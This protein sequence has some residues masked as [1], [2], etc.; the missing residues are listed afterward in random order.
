MRSRA[1]VMPINGPTVSDRAL[2]KVPSKTVDE[3]DA[4][5]AAATGTAGGAPGVGA[6]AV[7]LPSTE[8]LLV[9]IQQQRVTLAQFPLL[10]AKHAQKRLLSRHLTV[11]DYADALA[12]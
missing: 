1:K 10:I 2:V 5:A 11:R 4:P 9:M 6:T 7:T 12:A 8:Q 3:K